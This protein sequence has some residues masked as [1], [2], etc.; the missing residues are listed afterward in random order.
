[1]K[2]K[3]EKIKERAELSYWFIF[4]FFSFLRFCFSTL[5]FMTKEKKKNGTVCVCGKKGSKQQ[6]GYLGS[7]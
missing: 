7:G 3:K 2:M 4:L 1:M 6:V 5:Y